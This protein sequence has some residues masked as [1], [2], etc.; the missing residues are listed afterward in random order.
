MHASAAK[1][2]PGS[3][4]FSFSLLLHNECTWHHQPIEL[5]KL[6]THFWPCD[7]TF[8]SLQASAHAACV[9][10]SWIRWKFYIHTSTYAHARVY[11]W[12]Q[13]QASTASACWKLGT[14]AIPAKVWILSRSLKLLHTQIATWWPATDTWT[15][16]I[17][18]HQN[19]WQLTCI[20]MNVCIVLLILLAR[21]C[22]RGIFDQQG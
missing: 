3:S 5:D 19:S 16:W 17:L 2:T 15:A 4:D 7:L 14:A 12:S 11:G 8:C 10:W 22:I 13:F 21:W 18:L 1:A 6:N 20:V 9:F